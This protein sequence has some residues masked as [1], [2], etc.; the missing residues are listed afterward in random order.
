[1]FDKVT[2][3]GFYALGGNLSNGSNCGLFYWNLNNAVGNSNWNIGARLFS[4]IKNF[5]FILRRSEKNRLC[6]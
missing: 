3:Q 5:M 2:K 4:L 1:M 6:I